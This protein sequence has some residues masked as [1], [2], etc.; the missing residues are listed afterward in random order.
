MMSDALSGGIP[1]S[2]VSHLHDTGIDFNG[3]LFHPVGRAPHPFK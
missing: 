1:V 3:S 2:D